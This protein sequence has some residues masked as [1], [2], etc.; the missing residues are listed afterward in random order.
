MRE[1]GKDDQVRVQFNGDVR[2]RFP[3]HTNDLVMD[4]SEADTSEVFIVVLDSGEAAP[5]QVHHDT[6]QVL[7]RVGRDLVLRIGEVPEYYPV[8]AGDLVRIS[9][10][11]P[12]TMRS[13]GAHPLRYLAVDAFVGGKPK[14]E[15]T[16][17]RHVRVMCAEQGRDYA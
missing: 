5:L 14:D 7:L 8:R 4:R 15:P 2:Y 11:T 9:P 10:H 17:D 1:R 12:H 6:E 13:T 3:T 16:W